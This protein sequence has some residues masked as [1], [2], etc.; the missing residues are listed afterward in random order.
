MTAVET[1]Q[2]IAE[3]V[4]EGGIPAQEGAKRL[5]ELIFRNKGLFALGAL[6]HDQF[7]D[8]LLYYHARLPGVFK[9]YHPNAGMFYPF[10]RG[11]IRCALHTWKKR[12]FSLAAAHD[13]MLTDGALIYDEEAE[14]YR[15]SEYAYACTVEERGQLREAPPQRRLR[16]YVHAVR[17][18]SRLARHKETEPLSSILPDEK[19]S[20]AVQ[21]EPAPKNSLAG[22]TG[23]PQK[24]E[25]AQLFG[26]GHQTLPQE[27]ARFKQQHT[28]RQHIALVVSLK[29]SYYLE[30]FHIAKLS[31]LTGIGRDELETLRRQ[32]IKT[33]DRKI[34]RRAACIRCRDNAYF[35]HRKYLLEQSRLN[36]NSSWAF[37]I[38]GKYRKQ[39]LSWQ[40]KNQ[41][42]SENQYKVVASNR[43]V[44]AVLG[45]KTRHV[46]YLLKK[47]KD[48]MDKA[49][50]K[51]YD[52]SI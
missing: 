30:E 47:A 38:A 46:D 35:F 45:M 52:S 41:S 24:K 27:S 1:M 3:S 13:C 29:L 51:H 39:T 43:V 50:K 15:R 48:I 5:W 49:D 31:E 20:S 32:V 37:I 12:E 40:H 36:Q 6:D 4:H 19:A 9:L 18:G 21:P 11:N 7:M 22:H 44:G 28:L 25:V 23:G 26:T 14:K 10:L 34:K 17:G 8:F 2:S 42:L 33:L 16:T